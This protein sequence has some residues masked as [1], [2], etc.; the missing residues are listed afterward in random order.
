MIPSEYL[1]HQRTLLGAIDAYVSELV[2]TRPHLASVQRDALEHFARWWLEEG[3]A[4][5]VCAIHSVHIRDY[6][7]RIEQGSATSTTLR[8][9][10]DWARAESLMGASTGP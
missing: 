2:H 1:A 10:F 5:E 9:F 3:R 7:T 4:N 6:L 8:S